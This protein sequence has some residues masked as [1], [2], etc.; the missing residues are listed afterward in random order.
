MQGD[1]RQCSG[2]F[3]Q[4]KQPTK[5]LDKKIIVHPFGPKEGC[6]VAEATT[7]PPTGAH[8]RMAKHKVIP[9]VSAHM[10]MSNNE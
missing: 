3:S 4:V 8:L 9:V 10:H 2:Q 5:A 7:P 1:G 6:P